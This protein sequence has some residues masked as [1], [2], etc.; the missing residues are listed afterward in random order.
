MLLVLLN[1]ILMLPSEHFARFDYGHAPV[2]LQH[3]TNT[4]QLAAHSSENS[5]QII[6]SH[7]WI[8][9]FLRMLVH[10]HSEDAKAIA[11]S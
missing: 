1:E 5:A 9:R 7:R 2:L 3:N 11:R 6:C 10:T 8:V 4:I